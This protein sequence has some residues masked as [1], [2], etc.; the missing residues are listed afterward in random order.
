MAS[1]SAPTSSTVSSSSSLVVPCVVCSTGGGGG[2]GAA[3]GKFGAELAPS[4]V[5]VPVVVVFS[6]GAA[7][8]YAEMVVVTLAWELCRESID[9]AGSLTIAA[10]SPC[11]NLALPYLATVTAAW[12]MFVSSTVIWAKPHRR[13]GSWLQQ[14]VVRRRSASPTRPSSEYRLGRCWSRHTA[15]FNWKILG[16]F[17]PATEIG[18][19]N[20]SVRISL[21]KIPKANTSDATLYCALN[22]S[23]AR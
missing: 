6:S 13:A 14:R 10:S 5:T 18:T 2:G 11:S 20:F 8:A 12:R 1:I 22:A 21:S 17:G 4:V 19:G 15:S 16:A 7:T 23:G 3:A 9:T